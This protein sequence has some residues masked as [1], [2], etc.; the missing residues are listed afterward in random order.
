MSFSDGKHDG[1]I[2][3]IG[4]NIP[5]PDG[6]AVGEDG[7]PLASGSRVGDKSSAVLVPS[8]RSKRIA[9]MLDDLEN[10]GEQAICDPVISVAHAVGDL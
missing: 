4:R 10:T 3:G 7:S 2:L 6:S 9:N 8:A 1:P 5:T